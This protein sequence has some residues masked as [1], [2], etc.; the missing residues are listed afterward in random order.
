MKTK[1]LNEISTTISDKI[2]LQPLDTSLLNDSCQDWP[3]FFKKRK[4]D[5]ADKWRV[6]LEKEEA[7]FEVVNNVVWCLNPNPPSPKAASRL[8]FIFFARRADLIED[9]HCGFGHSSQLTV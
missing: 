1:F 5:W 3:I 6:Q 2:L 9:F 8:K 4:E 7:K